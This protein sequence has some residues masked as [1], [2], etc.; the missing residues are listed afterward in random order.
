MS[1]SESDNLEIGGMIT[2]LEEFERD[3]VVQLERLRD[4]KNAFYKLKSETPKD[5][6]GSII[7]YD[8]RIALKDGLLA[9]AEKILPEES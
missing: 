8:R 9:A 7:P 4:V 6:D 1:W 3:C 2:K 5:I